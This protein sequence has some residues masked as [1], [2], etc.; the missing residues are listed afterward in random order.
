MP[1]KKKEKRALLVL[2]PESSGTRLMTE[3]LVRSGCKGSS[4][5]SQPMADLNHAG[6]QEGNIVIRYSLPHT[7]VWPDIAY[8]AERLR[9][10]GFQVLAVVMTRAWWPMMESQAK[11]G[12]IAHQAS[13][14]I[15]ISKAYPFIL[16]HI[17]K[18]NIPYI[19]V[20]YEEMILNPGGY[21]PRTCAM[22][23]VPN[24]VPFPE[25]RNENL[26]HYAEFD[27]KEIKA[28]DTAGSHEDSKGQ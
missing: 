28:D 3:I 20:S 26:K 1:E 16:G 5:D 22:L 11:R 13:A 15:N 7:R 6:S 18:Q 17:G 2:G 23:H 12:H 27:K 14:M 24:P 8:T 10:H 25:I 4:G 9:A 19:M 21:I